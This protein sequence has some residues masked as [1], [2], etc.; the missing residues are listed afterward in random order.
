MLLLPECY[1][2]GGVILDSGTG[3]TLGKNQTVE[4][5]RHPWVRRIPWS[6]TWNEPL[7]S[8]LEWG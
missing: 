5:L 3:K 7:I 1:Y 4:N 8:T 2:T 6:T